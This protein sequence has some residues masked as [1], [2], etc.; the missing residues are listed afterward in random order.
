MNNMKRASPYCNEAATLNPDNTF[1]LLV[2]AQEQMD[3]DEFEA[4]IRTL[5]DAKEKGHPNARK[6]QDMLSKAHTLLKRSKSKDYYKVLGLTRDASEKEIKKA[7]R[8]LSQKFHPDKATAN[9]I[10]KD[11]AQKKMS[12]VNEAYEVLS[13]PELKQRFDNGDDPNDQESQMRGNPFQGNPFGGGQQFVFRQG[14]GSFQ[15]GGQGGFGGFPGGGFG[16]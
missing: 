1:A 3:S 4:A 16:F 5:N 6:L 2:K 12:E 7:W 10:P 14:G 15:F 13:D 9:G 11:E 8:K